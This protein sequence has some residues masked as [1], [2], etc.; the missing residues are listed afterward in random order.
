MVQTQVY[1]E[2]WSSSNSTTNF[3]TSAKVKHMALMI[4]G[5]N[6]DFND[7]YTLYKYSESEHEQK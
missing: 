4:T 1:F 3:L 6:D 2:I 7:S 5:N